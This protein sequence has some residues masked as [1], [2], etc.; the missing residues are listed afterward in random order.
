MTA[1]YDPAYAD[2]CHRLGVATGEWE[3]LSAADDG[4]PDAIAWC[5][6]QAE[7]HNIPWQPRRGGGAA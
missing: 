5:R 7:R 3:A 6:A 2:A 1:A 4:D